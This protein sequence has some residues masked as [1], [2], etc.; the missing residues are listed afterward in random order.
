MHGAFGPVEAE[1]LDGV[2]RGD[3]SA[4]ATVA[5]YVHGWALTRLGRDAEAR[6]VTRAVL[7]R[8]WRVIGTDAEPADLSA[9]L[10]AAASHEIV[11]DSLDTTRQPLLILDRPLPGATSA[12]AGLGA[13]DPDA[14][15]ATA[16]LA[17]VDEVLEP[18]VVDAAPKDDPG[19]PAAGPGGHPARRRRPPFPVRRL[20]V[21]G[22]ALAAAAATGFG[23]LLVRTEEPGTQAAPGHSVTVPGGPLRGP[24]ATDPADAS[25]GLS[26]DP[27]PTLPTPAPVPGHGDPSMPPGPAGQAPAMPVELPQPL[28]GTAPDQA[29]PTAPAPGPPAPAPGTPSTP[30]GPGAGGQTAARPPS[31][32]LLSGPGPVTGACH[33]SAVRLPVT[34]A[35]DSLLPGT[36]HVTLTWTIIKKGG[37]PATTTSRPMTPTGNGTWTGALGPGWP[38][39]GSVSWFAV[40]SDQ[41]GSGRTP[42]VTTTLCSGND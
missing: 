6:H 4:V 33:G 9:W 23:V 32:T 14:A 21:A 16:L 37:G 12:A 8:L 17:L 40:A 28:P 11:R 24:D 15:E 29:A 5:R 10:G 41:D 18:A 13:D 36:L 38:N 1:L 27:S 42:T 26:P 20:M 2:R 19:W 35:V 30:G 25:T 39:K 22:L 34:V 7:V 3:P 31:V